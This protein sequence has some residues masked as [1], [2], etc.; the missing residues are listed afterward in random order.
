MVM[1]S[2]IMS[3]CN[4]EEHV[5]EATES[6]L[7]QTFNDFEFI[8]VNDG[9][10]DKTYEI[11]K[12]HAEIDKRIKIM[13][14]EKREGLAK[15]LNDGIKIAKGK[16]IARMDADDISLPERLQR[17]VEFMERNPETGAIGSC[18]QEVDESGNILPRKQNP[19][20]WKDIKKALFFYN[21]ISHPTT[22]IRKEI[23][24]KTGTY[25][26]TFPTSQDYE[27]FSRIAQ[28]SELRNHDEVLLIRRFPKKMSGGKMRRQTIDS[29]RIQIRM[30]KKGSYPLHYV[31]FLLKNLIAL[32]IPVSFREKV[33]R[34]RH[35]NYN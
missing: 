33:R 25:D 22:M 3:V 30:L 15:S 26:E 9:S 8:I 27:L 16:Y 31:V 28:F 12:R 18:Y 7:D 34:W 21:P 29:L 23:L 1:I 4:E 5:S 13:S 10:V 2:V 32:G 14:H 17:Q 11:I 35:R 24:E 20:S 19:Q 6:I